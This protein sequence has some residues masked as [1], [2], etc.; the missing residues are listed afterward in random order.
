MNDKIK[1]IICSSLESFNKSYTQGKIAKSNLIFIE[2]TKQIWT[3]DVFYATKDFD[4]GV[5]QKL[6]SI[7]D[8]IITNGDGNM[9]LTDKGTYV[10]KNQLGNITVGSNINPVYFKEGLAQASSSTVG[11][12]YKPIFLNQGNITSCED[13]L[14]VNINGYVV[15]NNG[16]NKVSTLTALPVNKSLI[17]A[18]LEDATNITLSSDM[19]VGET[20]TIIAESSKDFIQPLPNTG[21]WV[22]MDGDTLDIKANKKFEIN[23]YCYDDLDGKMY[24]ISC[25]IMK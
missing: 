1:F 14:N 12:P 17:V 13:T 11:T 15:R 2:D 21:N 25:K 24:S 8:I 10:N 9:V 16:N 7:S 22:S 4:E 5:V 19:N 20:I 6:I 23:I 3:N 18:S